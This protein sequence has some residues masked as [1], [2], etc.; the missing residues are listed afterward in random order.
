MRP[1]KGGKRGERVENQRATVSDCFSPSSL[2]LPVISSHHAPR[3]R[4]EKGYCP[5]A[6]AAAA[7]GLRSFTGPS[8]DVATDSCCVCVCVFVC[9]LVLW[10]AGGAMDYWAGCAMEKMWVV[11]PPCVVCYRVDSREGGGV[12]DGS[13]KQS[14]VRA[15]AFLGEAFLA[16]TGSVLCLWLLLLLLHGC[17]AP[18]HPNPYA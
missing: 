17:C 8:S 10:L 4:I 11:A 15:P 9:G 14:V 7:R 2:F 6:V 12:F 5:G 1:F 13:L 18:A 3:P 16:D